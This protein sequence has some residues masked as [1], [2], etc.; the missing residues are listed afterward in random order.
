[1]SKLQ[2]EALHKW[3]P[4]IL[5]SG[6]LVGLVASFWQVVERIHMLKNPNAP[7]SCD[8]SPVVDCGGVLGDR[9]AALFGFPNAMIGMVLFSILLTFG[10]MLLAG[11]ELKKWLWKVLAGAIVVLILFS[12][13]F[14]GVSL[15]VI[16]KICI[17]CVF[18]WIVSVPIFIY[19][20]DWLIAHKYL[21]ASF[22][23][24]KTI[25]LIRANTTELLFGTYI[26]MVL[27]FL[28]RFRDFYF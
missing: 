16:G 7:L 21:R 24:S 15:F 5:T 8:I 27:L 1:M 14:F 25:T 3:F 20:M 12:L 2:T 28:Y 22:A 10:L 17:F 13:W 4:I 9:L 18:I 11:V 23:H 19:G 26:V 6:A